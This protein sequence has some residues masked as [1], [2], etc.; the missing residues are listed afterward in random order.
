MATLL[1]STIDSLTMGRGNTSCLTNTILGCGAGSSNTT[2]ARN[3]AI[4]A[5]SGGSSTG[6]D[7]VSLGYKAGSVLTGGSRNV[8]L[9]S[10]VGTS[11][12]GCD[13]VSVGQDSNNCTSNRT[14]GLGRKTFRTGTGA[15]NA[16]AVGTE[17]FCQNSSGCGVS[18]GFRTACGTTT[19][20]H[21]VAIGAAALQ[22]YNGSCN[23]AIGTNTGKYKGN[24]TNTT[25]LGYYSYHGYSNNMFT[26][27]RGTITS[28]F[29][30]VGWTNVS[31]ARDKTNISDLPD[32]LGLNFIRKLRPVSFRYDFR[33]HYM[34]ECGFEFGTKDGTLKSPKTSYG[35]LAQEV[36][37]AAKD[38]GV[39]FEGVDITTFD[40]SSTIK[41]EEFLSP[42]VKAIQEMNDELDII[43]QRLI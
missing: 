8:L 7:S 27:G 22:H 1:E 13:V 15:I 29:V 6:S 43:E 9:G 35:F 42:I 19:G 26:I 3:T 32:N 17:A 18:I 23:V 37:Q 40:G 39:N 10:N 33:K 4:G 30:Y 24:Y 25:K 34:F 16:V 21:N 38:L 12:T 28:A 2:G 31:D 20:C 5:A 36:E 11:S 41:L 14:V